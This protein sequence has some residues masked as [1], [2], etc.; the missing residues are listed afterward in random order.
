MAPFVVLALGG[1]VVL[2]FNGAVALLCGLFALMIVD[3]R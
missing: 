1:F 3:Y 2:C